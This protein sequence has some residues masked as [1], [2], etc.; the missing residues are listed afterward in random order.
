MG[1]VSFFQQTKVFN[2]LEER[3]R[4]LPNQPTSQYQ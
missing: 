3:I 2:V 4:C 1:T